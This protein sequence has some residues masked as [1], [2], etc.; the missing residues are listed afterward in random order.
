MRTCARATLDGALSGSKC[1]GFCSLL[2]IPRARLQ[3]CGGQS[4][5]VNLCWLVCMPVLVQV[6]TVLVW[7]GLS[8]AYG[9]ASSVSHVS[10]P[11]AAVFNLRPCQRSMACGFMNSGCNLAFTESP[12]KVGPTV[13]AFAITFNGSRIWLVACH[14]VYH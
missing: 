11:D 5:V 7:R 6:N 2:V 10:R 9:P 13:E 12:K 3:H 8:P 1:L 14:S 4:L